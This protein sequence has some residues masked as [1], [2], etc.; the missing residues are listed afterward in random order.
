[1]LQ[2]AE[3]GTIRTFDAPNDVEEKMSREDYKNDWYM[4]DG[5]K[6]YT[7]N[8]LFEGVFRNAKEVDPR[9]EKP[10]AED[11]FTVRFPG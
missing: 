10:H 1:M 9:I 5:R 6:I 2:K 8:R 3:P 7:V 11:G 4:Y